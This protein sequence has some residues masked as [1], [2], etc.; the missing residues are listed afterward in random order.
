M[1]QMVKFVIFNVRKRIHFSAY[2]LTVVLL[3]VR[4]VKALLMLSAVICFV[5]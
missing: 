2:Y 1:S 4:T 3:E 5:L